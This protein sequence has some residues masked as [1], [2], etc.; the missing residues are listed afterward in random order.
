MNRLDRIIYELEELSKENDVIVFSKE[1]IK[2]I[3]DILYDVTNS[4]KSI[5]GS[6]LK[7]S[8][9]TN[10]GLAIRGR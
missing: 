9:V 2:V 7:E 4:I 1:D 3:L 10:T 6:G 8:N 5:T